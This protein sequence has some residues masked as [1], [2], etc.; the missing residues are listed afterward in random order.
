MNILDFLTPFSLICEIDLPKFNELIVTGPYLNSTDYTVSLDHMTCTCK[1]FEDRI[2][3]PRNHFGRWC[4]HLLSELYKKQAFKF[5]SEWHRGI[6]EVAYSG[7]MVAY[8]F[9]HPDA[10]PIL[11]TATRSTEWLD[12]F[13][14]KKKGTEP[15]NKAEGRIDVFGWNVVQKR[16]SYGEGPPGASVYRRYLSQ[17]DSFEFQ[18]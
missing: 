4:K 7:P 8:I 3:Y 1:D 9:N 17:I 11:L 12:V 13:A 2:D 16:W 5:S 14:H 18:T 10:R 6:A 15:A